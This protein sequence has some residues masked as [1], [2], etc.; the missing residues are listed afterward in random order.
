MIL[1]NTV[2]CI[3]FLSK[4]RYY[5]IFLVQDLNILYNLLILSNQHL[6]VQTYNP[7]RHHFQTIIRKE[8]NFTGYLINRQK[9]ELA[10]DLEGL[11]KYD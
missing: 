9:F 10:W 2:G 5:N 8:G 4:K 11:W 1:S 7:E 3:D 6:R